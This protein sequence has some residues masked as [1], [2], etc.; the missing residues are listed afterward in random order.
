M[1]RKGF[2]L[3]LRGGVPLDGNQIF[4]YNINVI[5][6]PGG[7]FRCVATAKTSMSTSI[8]TK[9][10]PIAMT[11]MSI[12]TRRGGIATSTPMPTGTISTSTSAATDG[13]PLVR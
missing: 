8:A 12:L 5:Y 3:S 13:K 7:R 1:G 4:S 11:G 2:W 10:V 6:N 9:A